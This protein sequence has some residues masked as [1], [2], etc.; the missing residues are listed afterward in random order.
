MTED[1]VAVVT[2]AAGGIGAATCRLFAE[3]D[4][5]VVAIDRQDIDEAFGYR[6]ITTDIGDLGAAA[7]VLDGIPQIDALVNNAAVMHTSR[8]ADTSTED[9]QQTLSVN[10]SAAFVLMREALPA[11]ESKGGAVVN[12]ASVHAVATS[13]GAVAYAAS[14]AGLV[15]LTR[16]AALEFAEHGVRVNAVLPGATSTPMLDA[17]FS[18]HPDGPEAAA[19]QLISKTPL[20]RIADPREVAE[21]ILFLADSERSGFMT[22]QS[23]LLDGGATLRLSTE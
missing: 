12:V 23:L 10:V 4:W 21:A 11:L 2:G 3:A 17:G 5:T 8:L 16:A 18:R 15:G 6:V 9:W 1:R 20:R 13:P 22:G 14:K 19:Q 7:R